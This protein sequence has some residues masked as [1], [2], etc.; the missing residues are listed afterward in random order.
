MRILLL[1][2]VL[3]TLSNSTVQ[4]DTT[5]TPPTDKIDAA[6]FGI[7][8]RYPDTSPWPDFD[9]VNRPVSTRIWANGTSWY[10][11][12]PNAPDSTGHHYDFTVLDKLIAQ[13][14]LH[15]ANPIIVL[16][17]TPIW[18]AKYPNVNAGNWS[19]GYSS[20]PANMNDWKSYVTAV[21][22]HCKGRVF[23]YE[24]WNE[25]NTTEFWTGNFNPASGAALDVYNDQV[26]PMISMASTAYTAIKAADPRTYVLS[27]SSYSV[28]WLD[29]YL[30]AGGINSCDNIAYHNYGGPAATPE[31]R[32]Q[33]LLS[34]RATMSK[35]NAGG[36]W[37]FSTE[38]GFIRQLNEPTLS[39]TLAGQYLGRFLVLSWA[40]TARRAYW[41]SWDDI[42]CTAAE[43]MY[44]D[45]AGNLQTST[46]GLQ[47]PVYRSWLIGC[48]M[49]AV[50]SD[51]WGTWTAEVTR[52]D[53]SR[54]WLIW[55]INGNSTY[56]LPSAW[57]VKYARTPNGAVRATNGT[58]TQSTDQ[59]VTFFTQK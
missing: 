50:S 47:Y 30:Y 32:F 24:I 58:L 4:A 12:E 23:W 5:Y 44:V 35:Y 33:E 46:A 39:D 7:N 28:S 57:G 34:V 27:P 52:P 20:I 56:S 51:D 36:R 40:G 42:A 8:I 59:S 41:Y 21:V 6:Y 3:L 29:S 1:F 38:S 54:G 48:T 49:T 16:G 43:L 17:M 26:L 53:G 45:S 9:G 10:Q 37:L 55:N 13:A 11:I 14:N 2:M 25:P 22:T 15:G 18:A 31:G 19:Q